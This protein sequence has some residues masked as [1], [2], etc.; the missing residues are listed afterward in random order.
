MSGFGFETNGDMSSDFDP[1]MFSD[2]DPNMFSDFD[3]SRLMTIEEQNVL[4]DIMSNPHFAHTT[5]GSFNEL[6]TSAQPSR[7]VVAPPPT[8]LMAAPQ[9]GYFDAPEAERPCVFCSAPFGT[10]H[11]PDCAQVWKPSSGN[12]NV[13]SAIEDKLTSNAESSSPD[14][15]VLTPGA[16]AA[17]GATDVASHPYPLPP[18]ASTTARQTAPP[19]YISPYG[20]ATYPIPTIMP[21]PPSRP[22]SARPAPSTAST[23]R[24]AATTTN[25]SSPDDDAPPNYQHTFDTFEAARQALIPQ[26]GVDPLVKLNVTN[27]DWQQLKV[28]DIQSSATRLFDA[29]HAP[30]GPPPDNF[31]EEQKPYYH[32]HQ[33]SVRQTVLNKVHSYPS[34]AEA[35]AMLLLEQIIKVHEH[36]VPTSV[37][38]RTAFKLGYLLET[39]MICSQRL[40]AVID[41]VN[42]DKYV[43]L[44]VLSGNGIADLARSPVRYL[45]RKHENCRVN[46]RKAVEKQKAE[47]LKRAGMLNGKT[48]AAPPSRAAKK[49]PNGKQAIRA[50]GVSMSPR[51]PTPNIPST[52]MP[53]DPSLH[54]QS[55]QTTESTRPQLKRK[56][57]SDMHETLKMFK[58]MKPNP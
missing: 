8:P 1:N 41:A 14:L 53:F 38:T 26:Q 28:Y 44:D 13:T 48:P 29:L 12:K 42:G 7:G 4:G 25:D 58:Y 2:F 32:D 46:A 37:Y 3:F 45:R 39:G 30:A 54:A 15:T 19:A 52:Q 5:D 40:E 27:D 57:E 34:V 47:E 10:D 56:G 23:Q 11:D 9:A 24:Q 51:T 36:G 31:D 49:T 17:Q 43:A 6:D 50:E 18:K 33:A 21:P 35:R 55:S 22:V 16:T 20:P